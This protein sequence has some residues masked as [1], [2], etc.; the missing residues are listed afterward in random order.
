MS[1]QDWPPLHNYSAPQ[2]DPALQDQLTELG[3][4]MVDGRPKL[5]LV[6]GQSPDATIFWEGRRRMR[7]LYMTTR[8]FVGWKAYEI[9]G[10]TIYP[11]TSEPPKS[12]AL[13]VEKMWE[14]ED[15]GIPRWF[16]EQ[17]M[18]QDLI[19]LDWE[20]LRYD[21][22]HETN[23]LKD[24]LGP[25]PQDYY[26]EAFYMIADHS[27]CCPDNAYKPHCKGAYRNPEQYDVEYIKWL[28]AQ[29]NNEPNRYDWQSVPPPQV[30]VQSLL[31][32]KTAE[33]HASLKKRGETDYAIRNSLLSLKG[34]RFGVTPVTVPDLGDMFRGA[35]KF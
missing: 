27:Q 8:K 17:A 14:E 18:P 21:L 3:G 32:R 28:M 19:G 25:L 2:I 22:D 11:P 30:V 20:D 23:E 16:V 7:Y 31:D 24:S 1:I 35:R 13:I 9:A 5:R 12:D 33:L 15:I 29:L 6:W 4:M 10:V 34:K 26:E